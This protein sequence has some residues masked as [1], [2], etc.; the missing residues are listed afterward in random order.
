MLQVEARKILECCFG[1]A[2]GNIQD[3]LSKLHEITAHNYQQMTELVEMLYLDSLA[4]K[5]SDK[6]EAMVESIKLEAG[7]LSAQTLMI[8]FI[9][10]C[11]FNVKQF[12]AIFEDV[13][14]VEDLTASMLCICELM[15]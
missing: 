10:C 13:I 12:Q 7:S 6:I 8:G 9:A 4:I 5:E 1:L 11:V 14:N 2:L 3:S 15:G